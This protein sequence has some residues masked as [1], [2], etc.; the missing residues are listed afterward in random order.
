[1][2]TCYMMFNKKTGT[3]YTMFNKTRKWEHADA[4]KAL[5]LKKSALC[6]HVMECDHFIDW[7]KTS[8]LRS[9]PHVT[10]RRT[11]ESYLINQRSKNVNVL[12]RNDGATLPN[13]YQVLLK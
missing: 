12:N 5:D 7:D 11:A 13:V 9:E 2:G 1:M 4:V 8:I 10:R 3:C 6:Q